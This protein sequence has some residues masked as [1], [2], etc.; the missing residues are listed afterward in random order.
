M[1][2][3]TKNAH[4]FVGYEYKDITVSRNMESLYA[5]CYT[6]FGWTLEGA[7]QPLQGFSS[8]TLKFKRDRKIRNK[9]ELT[10]LQRQADSCIRDM[11]MLEKSKISGAAIAA[12][13]TGIVGTAFMAGSV[14][15][16]LADMLPL[17][18]LL[19]VPAFIGW[20]VPYFCYNAI[21]K[22]R[23]TKVAPLIDQKHDE[24]YEVC[25]KAN[26]LLGQ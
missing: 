23:A 10:R 18:I 25:E 17:S 16:Y 9:A 14:F 11:E 7:S 12:F 8:V 19:A 4:N 22:K 24:I 5:D 3:M 2:E 20:I 13:S 6:N 1:N 15:A 21:H 26:T